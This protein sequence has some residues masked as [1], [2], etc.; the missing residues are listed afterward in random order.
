MLLRVTALLSF[1]A[2]L[3][4]ASG[5]SVAKTKPEASRV[6]TTSGALHKVQ[7]QALKD[8]VANLIPNLSRDEATHFLVMYKNYTMYSMVKAVSADV[9]G[10]VKACAKNNK[11]MADDLEERF[12]Q[13]DK[14]VGAT[15]KE[16]LASINNMALAQSYLPQSDVKMIFKL[17]DDVRA[18]NSSRFET[19]PVTTPEACE[20]MM[21]KMD[22]T[23]DSMG[24]LLKI[25]LASY[26]NV[27]RATQ[28]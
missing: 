22:E 13:W 28:Q 21:S 3:L 2:I 9:S 26:P 18:V 12:A 6:E 25:T 1:F 5:I 19:S 24:R 15:M 27:L 17:V 20:F 10:A 8:V 7:T 11:G 23:Q 4:G 16:S 14:S